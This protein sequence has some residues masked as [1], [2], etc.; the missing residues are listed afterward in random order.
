LSTPWSNKIGILFLP[1]L[2]IA[3]C[4]LLEKSDSSIVESDTKVARVGNQYLY[5]SDLSTIVNKEMSPEDS[6]EACNFFVSD[7]VKNRLVLE[8]SYEYL[9]DNL[10]EIK[11]QAKEYEESLMV[12]LYETKLIQQNLDTLVSTEEIEDYYAANKDNFVLRKAIVNSRY[13]I[14]KSESPEIDSLRYWFKNANDINDEKLSDYGFQYA[15]K[16]SADGEWFELE[17][18]A[19]RFPLQTENVKSFVLDNE[20]IELSDKD[21][22]YVVHIDQFIDTGKIAPLDYRKNEIE[23]IIIKRRKLS[24]GKELREKIFEDALNKGEFDIYE[25]Q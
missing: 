6:L 18:F 21:K 25:N 11:R 10:K 22:L 13:F 12:F 3:A 20:F 2:L 5:Q 17:E 7:W 4:H 23:K 15:S 19:K 16:F 8:K 9:P 24:Y 1:I 14:L